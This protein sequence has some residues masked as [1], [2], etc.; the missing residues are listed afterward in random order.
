MDP[1]DPDPE[2][3]NVEKSVFPLKSRSHSKALEDSCMGNFFLDHESRNYSIPFEL[4]I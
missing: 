2:N 3:F 1:T 4:G